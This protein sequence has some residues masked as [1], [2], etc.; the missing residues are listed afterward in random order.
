MAVTHFN[1]VD[2][3]PVMAELAVPETFLNRTFFG[4][5][6]FF[7]GRF[8]QVDS[9]K[10]R[11]WLAPVV[12]RN[13]I[14]RVVAR[15]PIT[16]KFFEV[17][18]LRP[19]RETS[20]ADLDDRLLGESAYSRRTADERL[21]E[22]VAADIIDL[23]DA[24]TRRIEQ[25]SASLLFNGSFSYL[26]DDNSTETLSYGSVVPVVPAVLWD[27]TSGSD[28]IKDLSAAASA[29][30]AASGLVADTVVMGEAALS[31]FLNNTTV[32]NQLDKLHLIVG[33]IQPAAPQGIGSAQFVGTLYRPYVRLFGYSETY[34]DE[35]DNSLKPMID[36]KTVLLGCSKSPATTAFGSISQA[37]QDGEIRT[38]SDLKFV[39]RRL[40][41]PREDRTELRVA[42]RPCLIPY[43][44]SSW[45]VIKPL[46]AVF[47]AR[48]ESSEREER[49]ERR[50]K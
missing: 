42:S 4:R 13:Q 26:L 17:P 49:R 47:V 15:E 29:I 45:K 33:G 48:V 25:M 2:M 11:R 18:E 22:I 39:P 5:G 41:E 14:G 50:E 7:T 30:T 27:A 9:K 10:A 28:P 1:T 8:C 37:E 38:Y 12:K 6:T 43:D 35:A 21:A 23:V 16:T 24:I 31:A 46:P 34:E 3:L 36:P 40:T 44:L 20:V 32:Q 19:T